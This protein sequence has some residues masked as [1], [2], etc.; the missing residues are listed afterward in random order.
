MMTKSMVENTWVED[1]GQFL[2]PLDPSKYVCERDLVMFECIYISTCW[3]CAF[4]C[5][6]M[7]IYIYIYIYNYKEIFFLPYISHMYVYK[8]SAK[9]LFSFIWKSQNY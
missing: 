6:S 4:V 5:V 3:I 9:I 2:Y 1:M 7:C 8:V